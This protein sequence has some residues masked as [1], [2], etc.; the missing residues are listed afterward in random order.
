MGLL[1]ARSYPP[2]T[3]GGSDASISWLRL[4]RRLWALHY[5]LSFLGS[6]FALRYSSPSGPFAGHLSDVLAGFRPVEM[7]RVAGKNDHGARRISF[8]LTR[9]EFITLS[10][11]KDAGNHGIDSIL[12]VLVE[13][14]ASRRGA[15]LIP[16]SCKGGLTSDG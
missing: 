6:S 5:E 16:G 10:D 3:V 13:A 2:I 12:R 7:G 8:Q 11:I 9:I 14:S 4:S 1:K 15:L